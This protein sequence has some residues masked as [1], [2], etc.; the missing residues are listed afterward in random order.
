MIV[1]H[2]LHQNGSDGRI[3][4]ADP[5]LDQID[6]QCAQELSLRELQ[7]K[8][9]LV[10]WCGSVSE[11]C[12][13][14]NAE[15]RINSCG[16]PKAPASMVIDRLYIEAGSY[17][18]GGMNMQIN[19]KDPPLRMRHGDD[20]PGLLRWAGLQ[21][22]VFHDVSQ[23]ISWLV[24]G[25]SALLHLVRISLYRD[26]NDEESPYEWV[27]NPKSLKET[28]SGR[29][30]RAAALKTLSCWDNINLI[31][32]RKG[33]D[34]SGG[35][36]YAVFGNR[37]TELLHSLEILVD[38]QFT[39]RAEDGI[40]IPQSFKGR[41]SII[42]FDILD[43]V[44]PLGPSHT[45]VKYSSKASGQWS[46]IFTTMGATVIFGNNLGNL[47]VPVGPS[48]V[49]QSLKAVP[50]GKDYLAVSAS[51]LNMLWEKRLRRL[52]PDLDPSN[53]QLIKGHVW[54]SINDPLKTCACEIQGSTAGNCHQDMTQ[55]LMP[56]KSAKP[57]SLPKRLAP[58][59]FSAL[60]PEG[61]I[62][63][64]CL[65]S[66]SRWG[67]GKFAESESAITTKGG[68]QTSSPSEQV[69]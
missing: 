36:A 50:N 5:R 52:E 28:W 21:P 15:F 43:V 42:G 17:V 32:Y 61:A 55:V 45:R 25:I 46:D 1:W 56:M 12:G 37:V 4:Y 13:Q 44:A 41:P 22:I 20:Y 39:A 11:I 49:C 34:N 27:Y 35:P 65:P 62:L 48:P 33:M 19:K 7:N 8:R 47:L 16:L 53:G 2:V 38:R 3:S 40:K 51:T 6:F 54:A 18:I 26:E 29:T 10:G 23:S 24:D 63:F 60:K 64:K 57:S 67:P 66:K 68:W 9:H 14:P 31:L 69:L 59:D 58:F 30:G